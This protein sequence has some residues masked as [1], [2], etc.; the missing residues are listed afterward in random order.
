MFGNDRSSLIKKYSVIGAVFTGILGTLLHFAYKW[1][2]YNL[3][4]GIFSAVDESTFEHLKLLIWPYIFFMMVEFF[5]YGHRLDNFTQGK[6]IGLLSGILTVLVIFY[7]YS[8]VLGFTVVAVDVVIFYIAVIVAYFVSCR[9]LLKQGLYSA[10]YDRRIA[11][12]LLV[13][14]ILLSILF[15]YQ[16]PELGLFQNPAEKLYK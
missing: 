3:L 15:T 14:I 1:S 5:V 8:G 7:T 12:C 2:G 9:I 16:K 6:I 13:L 11:E 10:W 4:V